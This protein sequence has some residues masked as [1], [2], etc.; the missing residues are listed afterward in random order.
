MPSAGY[1]RDGITHRFGSKSLRKA[2]SKVKRRLFRLVMQT[3]Q[4]TIERSSS[5]ID[6]MASSH[7][8]VT[9]T[10]RKYMSVQMF[11]LILQVIAPDDPKN[12]EIIDM[13]IDATLEM[14]QTAPNAV[15]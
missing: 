13:M 15:G 1:R 5:R 6:D 10:E 4:R 12:Q 11:Y 14:D 7:Q 9:N 8:K 3:I 2:A